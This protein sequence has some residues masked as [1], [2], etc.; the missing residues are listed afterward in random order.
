MWATREPGP[1]EVRYAAAGEAESVTAAASRLV[2]AAATGFSFDY[3]QHEANLTGLSP[4]TTYAYDPFVSGVDLTPQPGT[5]RT[6]PS[7]GSGAVT[8]IAFGDSGT[9]SSAQHQ[10]ASL[11]A[12]DTFDIAL[13]AGDI[14]YGTTSGVGDASYRGYEDWFF[15]IYRAWLSSRPFFP[16]EGNHDSRPSNG[17]GVAYLDV[18]SLSRNGASPQYPE[19][20]ERYYSFDYGPVHFVALDTEFT[21]QDVTRRAEQIAWLDADLASTPQPW[22]IAYFHRSPYS[23]GGE[24]GSDLAVRSA[25][26]PLFER[27]GVQLAISAHEHDYE[28][29]RPIREGST[30]S[31]VTYLVTGGGGGPLYP[32]GTAAWTAYSASRHHYLRGSADDCTLRVDAIGLDGTTFDSATL[33]RCEPPPPP[34]P[35]PPAPAEVVLYVYPLLEVCQHIRQHGPTDLE[36]CLEGVSN[37]IYRDRTGKVVVHGRARSSTSSTNCRR[38]TTTWSTSRKYIIP[39]MAGKYVIS[40][41]L[42]RGCPFKCTFCDAPITMGKKLRFWSMDRI[43]QDIRH[44]VEKYGCHN[45]VFKDS[46]FTANKKWADEFCDAIMDSGLKI[47]WRCNTRVNLVPPPL[48]EKMK[49]AGCYVINFGVESG[50]PRS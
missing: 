8:F 14:T 6:A 44:Y 2:P 28:R 45:F 5:L 18:F 46:T 13:H 42:S 43:I 15:A 32:A 35:P 9:N 7:D 4:A 24:H 40:M 17:N 33:G 36:T 41:M 19:H 21:F 3:Y 39:T 27:H 47:K 34:P 25:F 49:K 31:H 38:S 30:G 12:A 22:K 10:L 26:G 23:A 29:T 11:M 48:L 37:V 50:D 1:A 16:V 20:A